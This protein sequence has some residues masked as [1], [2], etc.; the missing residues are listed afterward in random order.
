[1]QC[2]HGYPS[3]WEPQSLVV[4]KMTFTNLWGVSIVIFRLGQLD[5]Y[6]TGYERPTISASSNCS[7]QQLLAIL[8]GGD[9]DQLTTFE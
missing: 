2:S 1:M 6:D 9:K 5:Y 4:T 3:Y 8:L 7:K